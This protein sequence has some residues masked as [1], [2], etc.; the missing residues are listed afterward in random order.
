[1]LAP[2]AGLLLGLAACLFAACAETPATPDAAPP[3]CS[4]SL[5]D[6][7][8]GMACDLVC[9]GTVSKIA[10][11]AIPADAGAPGQTCAEA[12]ACAKGAGCY[13]TSPTPP[14]STCVAY[15]ATDADCPTGTTCK[16]RT[17]TRACGVAPPQYTV[18]LCRP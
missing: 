18:K 5:Q 9:D 14:L 1:M 13:A 6:C 12:T 11:R 7:P 8:D 10:C 15:C 3:E 17:V 2:R 4:P 16:T